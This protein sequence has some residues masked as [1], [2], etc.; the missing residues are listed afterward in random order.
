VFQV[1]HPDQIP[2]NPS[3]R[4]STP[5]KSPSNW[6]LVDS[7]AM[8]IVLFALFRIAYTC[9]ERSTIQF[10]TH[11]NVTS[12]QHLHFC[13]FVD[14]ASGTEFGGAIAFQLNT[15]SDLSQFLD[16]SFIRCRCGSPGF[17][18][19]SG[20]AISGSSLAVDFC[21]CQSSWSGLGHF[22]YAKNGGFSSSVISLSSVAAS[23]CCPLTQNS[24]ST[25]FGTIYFDSSVAVNLSICNFTEC[26]NLLPMGND[27]AA[28]YLESHNS[29]PSNCSFG[30]FVNLSG[31]TG[32]WSNDQSNICYRYCSIVE[33]SC[34]CII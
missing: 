9:E 29:L 18:C 11:Y 23:D 12:C 4:L 27:G 24:A 21:C 28:L 22:I 7:V 26:R 2:L 32:L 34:C 10:Q 19:G 6:L 15:N 3:A 33:N 20:I 31:R 1:S 17:G 8:L 14:I 30:A 16:C 5:I 13:L 25:Q